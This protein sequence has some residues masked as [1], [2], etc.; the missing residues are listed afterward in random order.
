MAEIRPAVRVAL[1]DNALDRGVYRPA[2]HWGPRLHAAGADWDVFDAPAGERPDLDRGYTHLLLT[3][4]EASI[5]E[6]E[7]WA[8]AEAGLVREAAERGLAILGSCWGHQLLAYAIIGPEAVGRCARPEIGWI[9]I[10][11]AVP[12]PVL[13]PAGEFHTFAIHFDEVRGL[14]ASFEVLAATAACPIHA[15]RRRGRPI[16]GIQAHPEIE[17]AEATAFLRALLRRPETAARDEIVRALRAGP[18]D[19]GRIGTIVHGFL[20]A[21]PAGPPPG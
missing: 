2:F 12:D 13:G 11:V 18:L 19:S 9:P 8:E 20:R 10:R 3:G 1:L 4:S 6:R 7:P 5:V 17:P 14:D 16:W 15:F 21:R